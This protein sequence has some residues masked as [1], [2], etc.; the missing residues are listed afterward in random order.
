MN[1]ETKER[2]N[3]ILF[4]IEDMK[5]DLDTQKKIYKIQ[6]DKKCTSQMIKTKIMINKAKMNYKEAKELYKRV[7][8]SNHN[9]VI[10]N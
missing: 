6:K 10:T 7:K 5:N 9:N 1:I 2:L 8:V 4:Y 3:K